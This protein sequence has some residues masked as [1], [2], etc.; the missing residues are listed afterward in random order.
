MSDVT[1]GNGTDPVP[2][3]PGLPDPIVVQ[4]TTGPEEPR[5]KIEGDNPIVVDPS[6]PSWMPIETGGWAGPP[7]GG[8]SPAPEPPGTGEVS[9]AE[10]TQAQSLKA[11]RKPKQ[12]GG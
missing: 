11:P 1:N 5:I 6:I 9:D 12:R 4:P 2:T 3:D 8:G 7:G 10:P